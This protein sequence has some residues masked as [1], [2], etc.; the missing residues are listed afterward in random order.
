MVGVLVGLDFFLK[1]GLVIQRAQPREAGENTSGSFHHK[2][3]EKIGAVISAEAGMSRPPKRA[4]PSGE[5]AGESVTTYDADSGTYTLLVRSYGLESLALRLSEPGPEEEC[6]ISLE[7]MSKCHLPFMPETEMGWSPLE[8]R[9][10][11]TK[12]S[13][14]CGHSFNG[15]ALLYHFAKNSMTCPF[16]RAG[17]VG[18][19]MGEKSIPVHFRRPFISHLSKVQAEDAREQVA[20]DSVEAARILENEVVD[21]EV[22]LPLTRVV[23]ILCAYESL[24]SS[25]PGVLSLEL[26]LTSSQTRDTRAFVSSG[27]CLRQL[28]LN[29]RFLPMQVR[30][31][32][33]SV[34]IRSIFGEEDIM[35][36][37]TVRFEPVVGG[38]LMVASA[39]QAG[40]QGNH[41]ATTMAVEV[42]SAAG[43]K[44]F[45]QVAWT[46]GHSDFSALLVHALEEGRHH[47]SMPD[48]V[49]EV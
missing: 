35:L 44:E 34:G 14:P 37:R 13:L 30:A 25:G 16:C 6:S 17:H 42:Q 32:E 4:C 10:L 47:A 41:H 38:R 27:Y 39:L 18:V 36:F 43:S 33:I 7:D 3:T 48:M 26:P 12:A 28:A 2:R 15:M 31:F 5:E 24:D 45:I 21:L 23:L 29:L 46:V 8:G 22:L 1:K 9:P 11:L 19:V 20:L 49:A 40:E